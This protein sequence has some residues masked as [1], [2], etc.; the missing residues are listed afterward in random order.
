MKRAGKAGPSLRYALTAAQKAVC[1]RTR[2]G[3]RFE[4]RKAPTAAPLTLDQ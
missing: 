3:A 4:L 1:A 2:Q